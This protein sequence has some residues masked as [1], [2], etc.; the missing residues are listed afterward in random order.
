MPIKWTKRT[1][2]NLDSILV[3]IA[4]DN[5]IAA[6]D[7][8]MDILDQLAKLEHFPLLGRAGIVPSTRELVVHE[9]YI[10][11]YRVRDNSIEILQILHARRQYP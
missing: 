3:H 9:N 8:A 1:A 7:F 4:T 6:Q 11:Y 2:N 5:P 10:V